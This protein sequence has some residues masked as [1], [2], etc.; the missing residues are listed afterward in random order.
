MD[1]ERIQKIIADSGL[2]SRRHA[3]KMILDKR[4]L[5]NGKVALIGQKAGKNDKIEVD[6]QAILTNSKEKLYFKFNKP[7]GY[8]CTN[9]KFEK[10]KNIFEL[11]DIKEKL[12]IV[13]R[14]D[15]ESKGLLLLTNDGDFANKITHPKFEIKKEYIVQTQGEEKPQFIVSQFQ[16]GI[17]SE[18]DFLKAQKV[19]HLG[20]NKFKVILSQ[21]KKRQ[22]RRMFE[23]LGS[24][25]L[26]LQRTKIGNIDLGNLLPGKYE[27]IKK[28]NL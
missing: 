20:N 11:I 15:K 22:I 2:C 5:V 25:V 4:V 24:K 14:L 12:V 7:K 3:E 21:G 16:K 27:K 6:G 9:A 28:P 18:N 1:Q 26:D 8:V 19:E 23:A 13:G 10:E 17:K